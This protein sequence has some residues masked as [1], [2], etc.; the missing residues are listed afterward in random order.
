MQALAYK[1]ERDALTAAVEAAIDCGMVPRSD[2][3]TAGSAYYE[4]QN[5]VAEML[6]DALAKAKGGKP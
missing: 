1:Y 4:R 2:A 3:P 6:R 5:E